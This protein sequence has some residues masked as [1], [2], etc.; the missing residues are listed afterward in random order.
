MQSDL[1]QELGVDRA[2]VARWEL[3]TREPRGE[4]RERYAALLRALAAEA[5]A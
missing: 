2:T 4:M 1:S 5:G 3:G